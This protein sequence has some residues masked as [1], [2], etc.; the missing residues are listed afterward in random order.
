MIPFN[1]PTIM[2]NELQYVTEVLKSAKWSGDGVFTKRCEEFLQKELGVKKALLTTSCTDAL[3]MSALLLELNPGDEV[4]VPS[5]TFVSSANAFALYGARPVFVDVR[6]DTLNIN[7]DLIEAL[8]TPRTKAIVVVHYAGV[9]CA[10]DKICAVAKRH[11][12]SVIEDNA[13]GLFGTWNKRKLGSIG[14]AATLSFHDTKN[15]SSGE[16]GALLLTDDAD[17]ERA[18]VLREKGTNRRRFLRGQVDKY[19]WVDLGSSFLPSE[20]TAAILL[21]QLE[22][23][24]K[25]QATRARIWNRYRSELENWAMES[26]VKLQE[27]PSGVE[28]THHMFYMVGPDLEWR[29]RFIAYLKAN[30][31]AAPFH[32]QSLHLSDMGLK[33]GGKAGDCPVTERLSDCLVRLPLWNKMTDAQ[34]DLVVSTI[35]KFR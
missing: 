31:I 22:M 10:M 7:E 27:V 4:L 17:I 16:G 9:G 19:T 26:Q 14:R 24:E 11:N 34:V 3:E 5:F 28:Q 29:T 30:S 2:G 13:H 21:A 1:E 23:K 20:I 8:I 32:Y 18:E 33:F 15:F 12:L 6:P 25:I 35:H